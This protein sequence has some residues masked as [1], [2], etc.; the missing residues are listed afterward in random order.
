VYCDHCSAPR[1]QLHSVKKLVANRSEETDQQIHSVGRNHQRH[2]AE[3][4]DLLGLDHIVV[5]N[6]CCKL[7]VAHYLCN[8][9]SNLQER[10]R[11]RL[12]DV[13]GTECFDQS[14]C[15]KDSGLV[16]VDQKHREPSVGATMDP[17]DLGHIVQENPRFAMKLLEQVMEALELQLVLRRLKDLLTALVWVQT[18]QGQH[19]LVVVLEGVLL[20]E[21]RVSAAAAVHESR[22]PHARHLHPPRQLQD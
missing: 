6:S 18:R 17:E 19:Q 8:R 22:L 14:S 13:A 11:K 5:D 12:K 2:A 1:R 7:G 21:Q 3:I 16:L 4:R 15:R 10:R 20:L 9:K